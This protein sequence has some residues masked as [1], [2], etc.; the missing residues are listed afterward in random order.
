MSLAH[1]RAWEASV[2]G[3][4]GPPRHRDVP[5]TL[6]PAGPWGAVR[7]A[8]RCPA[9]RPARAPSRCAA[10]ASSSGCGRHW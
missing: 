9:W 5:S 2:G 7:Q 3:R 10:R 6:R 4:T 8:T 1:L